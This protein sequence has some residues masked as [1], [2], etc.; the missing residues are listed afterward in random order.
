MLTLHHLENSQSFR[1]VWLLEE[2]N[3]G[4]EDKVIPYQIKLYKRD[5]SGLAPLEYKDISPLGT[6]PTITDNEGS[7]A[8]SESNA[9]ID[10]ILDKLEG[11]TNEY[12]NEELNLR[13]DASHPSRTDY[14][15]WYHCSSSSFM[16]TIFSISIL[17][18]TVKKVPLMLTWIFEFIFGKVRQNL[19]DPRLKRLLELANRQL[20]QHDFLAG[21]FF[22]A[23]DISTIYPIDATFRREP[24]IAKDFPNCKK[25]LERMYGRPAFQKALEKIDEKWV[26]FQA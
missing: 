15:F 4:S 25:W 20:E 8:L 13:P 1:I 5:E 18:K 9:I 6:S 3:A 19:L 22:T 23:A 14:L 7:F 2:L 16:M 10:Y 21:E 12:T 26:S 24:E 17:R 11:Q